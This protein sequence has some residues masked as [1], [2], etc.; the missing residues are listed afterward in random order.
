MPSAPSHRPAPNAARWARVRLF[1]M[2]VDGVLT[3]GTVHI[4][5]DGSEAKAFSILDGHGL[6]RLAR[7]IGMPGAYDQG[8]QRLNWA[9]H[10]LTNWQGDQGFTRRLHGRV[11]RPNLV[12]DL[13]RMQ[14]EVTGKRKEGGEALID[15]RWWG[16]NQ[17]GEKNCDGTAVVRLPSRDVSLR[18]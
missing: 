18:N 11:T 12:G 4:S 10:L 16:E 2:D 9:G 14:G 13:T 1:A 5:S 3:D 17:R 15:I 7:E 8:W 6:R